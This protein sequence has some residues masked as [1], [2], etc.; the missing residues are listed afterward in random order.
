M[1]Y[2]KHN[3]RVSFIG[4]SNEANANSNVI[5]DVDQVPKATLLRFDN[6]SL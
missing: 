1:V 4:V 3:G 2:E 6:P 5:V